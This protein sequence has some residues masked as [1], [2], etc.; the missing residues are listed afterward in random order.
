MTFFE[1]FLNFFFP[2]F[3]VL[4]LDK[5]EFSSLVHDFFYLA[6]CMWVTH[7]KIVKFFID[8]FV[9]ILDD[10]VDLSQ[11]TTTAAPI[12]TTPYVPQET[13]ANVPEATTGV[14]LGQ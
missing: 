2:S 8:D 12:E 1:T 13:T 7:G 11:Q 5:I 6:N 4:I 14:E 10:L 3:L 9:D